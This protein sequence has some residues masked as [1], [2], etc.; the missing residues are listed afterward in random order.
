MT[1]AQTYSWIFYAVALASQQDPADYAG[2]VTVADG[3]NHAV[4][5]QKEM[6]ASLFWLAA[7]NL[8]QKD[9]KRYRLTEAGKLLADDASAGT[10]MKVWKNL[11]SRLIQLG[12]N[13]HEQLNPRTM[14]A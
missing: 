13:D 11:E 7:Q 1:Q 2:I 10:T 5:T 6:R 12:A 4:P 9:G 8:V 14:N 3:I